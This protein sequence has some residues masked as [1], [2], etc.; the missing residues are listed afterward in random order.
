MLLVLSLDMIC[1]QH[2][3]CCF[4]PKL[5]NDDASVHRNA[6]GTCSWYRRL[7]LV[8][9]NDA[10]L[11]CL[12]PFQRHFDCKLHTLDWIHLQSK[13]HQ[14][15]WSTVQVVCC[16]SFDKLTCG[17]TVRTQL[18]CL[19]ACHFMSRRLGTAYRRFA[20]AV[21]TS[22]LAGKLPKCSFY[23]FLPVTQ[24]P[25]GLVRHVGGLLKSSW[26]A[27]LLTAEGQSAWSVV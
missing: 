25:K 23:V 19:P 27:N 20:E 12:Q 22:N 17:E 1:R 21:L 9:Y 16:S 24:C 26:Q 8:H 7:P 18:V 15:P 13:K 4:C 6:V 14:L 5:S 2:S 11:L 10:C 3:K